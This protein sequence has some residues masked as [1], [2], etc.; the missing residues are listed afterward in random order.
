MNGLIDSRVFKEFQMILYVN[1]GVVDLLR[2]LGVFPLLLAA[3]YF[4]RTQQSFVQF[5][6]EPLSFRGGYSSVGNRW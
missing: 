2:Y 1:G 4:G 3:A 5:D 6:A